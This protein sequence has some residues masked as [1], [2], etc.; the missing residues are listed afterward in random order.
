MQMDIFFFLM[1]FHSVAIAD[2]PVRLYKFVIVLLQYI[3]ILAYLYYLVISS[4]SDLYTHM[5]KNAHGCKYLT[6]LLMELWE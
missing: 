1:C 6:L 2:I 3:P 5:A 4:S